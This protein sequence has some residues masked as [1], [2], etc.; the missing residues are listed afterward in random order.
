MEGKELQRHWLN[1]QTE[2]V[3]LV[4]DNTK[5]AETVSRLKSEYNVIGQKCQRLDQKFEQQMKVA[6][7]HPLP[8]PLLSSPS[9]RPLSLP[10]PSSK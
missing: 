10:S 3:Q 5:L 1:F 8:T 6:F 7:S 9:P 4:A 2:L